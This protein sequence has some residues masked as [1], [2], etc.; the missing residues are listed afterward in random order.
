MEKK[1]TTSE[2]INHPDG[3]EVKLSTKAITI[4]GLIVFLALL[5]IGSLLFVFVWDEFSSYN[6]GFQIGTFAKLF[7]SWEVIL[8]I[9]TGL[10]IY[11]LLQAGILYW[12][13]GKDKKFLHW[14][15]DWKGAGFYLSRPIALK[16]Y[17]V[18]LL[19][20]SILLGLLPIIHGFCIGNA[21][22]FYIGMYGIM[23]ASGDIYFWYKLRPFD[24]EDLLLTH[25][26]FFNATI[27]KR[28]YGK[29]Y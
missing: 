2:N 19:L 16:Y 26:D 17:R 18:V 21:S 3:V 10:A 24:E 9:I 12:F 25:G 27:I 15:F 22:I 6:V 4:R 14:Q 20:P 29:K 8:I 1:D 5:I 28:N 7:T 13:G 11:I 23:I